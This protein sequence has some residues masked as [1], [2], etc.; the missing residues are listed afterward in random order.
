M[1]KHDLNI[2]L[3]RANPHLVS[4]RTMFNLTIKAVNIN[5]SPY[6]NKKTDNQNC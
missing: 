3:A 5:Y 4:A 6:Y 2:L 1:K